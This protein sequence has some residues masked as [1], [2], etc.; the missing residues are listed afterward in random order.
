LCDCCNFSI[1]YLSVIGVL[2]LTAHID[3]QLSIR[4]FCHYW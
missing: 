4:A 2:G 1:T 3:Y